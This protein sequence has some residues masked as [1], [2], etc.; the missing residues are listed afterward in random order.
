MEFSDIALAKLLQ[1]VPELGPLILTFKDVSDELSD[2]SGIRVGVFVLRSGSDLF[3]IPVVSKGDNVY[4]TDSIFFDSKKKFFPLTKKTVSLVVSSSQ[5]EQGKPTKIPSTVTINPSVQ[6]LLTPPRTGKYAYASASR[7]T[8]FLAAMPDHL[9]QFTFEKFAAEKSVYDDLDKMF[10]LKAI[11]DVLNP[12]K[13]S[14]AAVT[15]ESPISVVTGASPKIDNE[16]IS[17]ILNDGYHISGSAP[18]RRV[19]ISVQDYNLSGTVKEISEVDGDR[20]YELAFAHSS[21]REAFIPK[22]H[23]LNG[24]NHYDLTLAIFTNGDYA[25]K[26]R[27]ISVKDLPDRKE[28]LTRLFNYNP[29]ILLREVNNGDTIVISTNSGEFLGPFN[30]SKVVLNHLGV[31]V[32]THG[33]DIVK[34]CGYNNFRGEAELDQRVLYIPS[35]SIVLRLASNVT[36]E[37]ANSVNSAAKRRE[38]ETLQFLGAELNLGYDGIEYSLNGRALGGEPEVMK[39][40]VITEGID[41]VQAKSFVKQAQITKFTKIYLTKAS[42]IS[43]EAAPSE[44]PNQG[45]LPDTQPT[46]KPNGAYSPNLVGSVQKTMPLSDGQ[47]T[48]SAIISELLQVPDMYEQ[49]TEYLPDIEESIDKIGRIL[50]M[51]RVHIHKLAETTDSESVFSFLAQLKAVYRMLGDNYLKLQELVTGAQGMNQGVEEPN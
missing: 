28:V 11:F 19:A 35:N 33:R 6:N 34:V 2:E 25:V 31:E 45:Q 13:Q 10:S 15:N 41:P 3:Y 42:S 20:D 8:D 39:A 23:K 14:L 26:N 47:V 32:S 48:E 24:I 17:N 40:L 36:H 43:S 49:I 50:F 51:S 1:T 16:A 4:P 18:T 22:L 12:A 46:V 21:S 37:L 27:F 7:L 5:L 9:K 44:I 38:F 29:P 30:V